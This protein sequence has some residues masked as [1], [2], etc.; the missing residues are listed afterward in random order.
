MGDTHHGKAL[1]LVFLPLRFPHITQSMIAVW[2]T[3][4]ASA[5]TTAMGLSPHLISP[6]LPGVPY[7]SC[8]LR[9]GINHGVGATHWEQGNKMAFH[10]IILCNKAPGGR[11]TINNVSC[12]SQLLPKI[13]CSSPPSAAPAR[14]QVRALPQ[15]TGAVSPAGPHAPAAPGTAPRESAECNSGQGG[16]TGTPETSN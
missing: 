10:A 11:K 6:Q 15:D 12:V 1:G 16:G 5:A 4:G 13:K 8:C 9:R 14:A 2:G 3:P 7:P